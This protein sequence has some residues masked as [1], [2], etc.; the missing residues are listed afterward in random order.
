MKK[1]IALMLVV[2]AVIGLTSCSQKNYVEI[3]RNDKSQWWR[4]D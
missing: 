1:F 2:I 3:D 4:E